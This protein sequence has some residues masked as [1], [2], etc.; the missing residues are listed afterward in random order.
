MNEVEMTTIS[1][2]G[3]VVIP[4][5][6]RN[7]LDIKPGTKFAVYGKNDLVILKKVKTPTIEDFERL[8]DFGIKFAKKKGIKSEQQVVD[9]I[10]EARGVR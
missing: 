9:M 6:I 7:E 3:Q 4:Q 2:K 8:V 10:H 5:E 1:I